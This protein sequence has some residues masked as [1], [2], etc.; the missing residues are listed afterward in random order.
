[1]FEFTIPEEG[2]YL[3]VDHDKLSQLP[4]GLVIPIVARKAE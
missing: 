3:L 2:N 1:M 4:N